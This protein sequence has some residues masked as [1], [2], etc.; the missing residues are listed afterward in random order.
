M[1]QLPFS[2]RRRQRGVSMIFALLTV[3]V[4]GLATLALMRSVDTGALLLGN[5]SF[6]QDAT[7]SADQGVR[8]AFVWLKEQ[9]AAK[10]GAHDA[11]NGYYAT[12]MDSDPTKP[13]DPTGGQQPTVKTRQLIDW[14]S[15]GCKY[16]P[17]TGDCSLKS[18]D[19]G[20][21]PNGNSQMRYAIFRLCAKT[22]ADALAS[23]ISNNCATPAGATGGGHE[24]GVSYPKLATSGAY[25]RVVVRVRGSRNSV[26]YIE[27]IV[28]L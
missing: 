13:V 8:A 17:T 11:N 12:T 10:L 28:Q 22:D 21:T 6:K 4:L 25:Y 2:L 26:S 14:D 20:E 9:T 5:V 27:T 7:V 1:R 23:G 24:A 19:G 3:V 18:E 16:A 15:D